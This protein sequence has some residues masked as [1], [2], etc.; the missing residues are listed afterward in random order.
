ML[1]QNVGAKM[2]VLTTSIR[3]KIM[4]LGRFIIVEN[5]TSILVKPLAD[6]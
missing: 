6:R 4:G 1:V 3:R 2:C 5:E